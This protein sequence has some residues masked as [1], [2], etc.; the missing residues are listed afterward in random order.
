[1][2]WCRATDSRG[3]FN[4]ST[5]GWIELADSRTHA[6]DKPE[7]IVVMVRNAIAREH[8]SHVVSPLQRHLCCRLHPVTGELNRMSPAEFDSVDEE[9]VRHCE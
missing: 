1:M 6:W 8:V 5:A 4:T 2:R 7:V 3:S 9:S